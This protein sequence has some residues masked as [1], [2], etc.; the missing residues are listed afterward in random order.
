MISSH[1]V[2][3]IFENL[4]SEKH[5]SGAV[6]GEAN[7]LKKG[8]PSRTW[9]QHLPAGLFSLSVFKAWG[10]TAPL[11]NVCDGCS[12]NEPM[13]VDCLVRDLPASSHCLLAVTYFM[14][15]GERD[16]ANWSPLQSCLT[17]QGSVGLCSFKGK[18]V[19]EVLHCCK[20]GNQRDAKMDPKT[21]QDTLDV[22]EHMQDG[23]QTMGEL[24]W[25]KS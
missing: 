4:S 6:G 13:S 24:I 8:C 22:L 18:K 2:D 10:R 1:Y 25:T 12:D 21:M 15:H 14:G 17:K 7:E 23:F 19:F 16:T 9:L 11:A 20:A 5:H 3:S